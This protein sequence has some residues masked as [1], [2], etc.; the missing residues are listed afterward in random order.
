MSLPNPSM[1]FS[2]FAI[3]TAAEMN[4]LVENDQALAAGTGLN[5]G[6]VTG[7]KL[8]DDTVG[9]G[10]IDFSTMP[11]F[12]AY[13]TGTPQVLNPSLSPK[14]TLNA[15]NYDPGSNFN[16]SNSRFTAPVAGLYHFDANGFLTFA[17]STYMFA[18][19]YKNG[20]EYASGAFSYFNS[21]GGWGSSVAADIPLAANDYVELF[22]SAALSSA[23][24]NQAKTFLDG[25]MVVQD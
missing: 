3:L 17:S 6:A 15:E 18:M 16:I 12:R 7:T 23:T 24:V 9:M 11:R 5:D 1:S 14:V 20:V 2:P 13:Q 22:V 8:T 4:D 10:K 19:L 21:A 25:R